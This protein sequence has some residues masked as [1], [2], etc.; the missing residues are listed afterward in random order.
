MCVEVPTNQG[1]LD[2]FNILVGD[3]GGNATLNMWIEKL[4]GNFDIIINDDRHHNCQM[5]ASSVEL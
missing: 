3:Q 4:G 2:G 1:K 5:M